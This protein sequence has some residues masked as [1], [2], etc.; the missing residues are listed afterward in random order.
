MQPSWGGDFAFRTTS[1]SG[2]AIALVRLCYMEETGLA[3][4]FHQLKPKEFKLNIIR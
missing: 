2:V 3:L 1:L 4:V